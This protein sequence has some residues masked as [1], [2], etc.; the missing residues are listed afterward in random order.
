VRFRRRLSGRGKE[1]IEGGPQVAQAPE[2]ETTGKK[3]DQKPKH[4]LGISTPTTEEEKGEG[5]RGV[6]RGGGGHNRCDQ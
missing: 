2:W 1:T 4:Q 5:G 6:S 3:M